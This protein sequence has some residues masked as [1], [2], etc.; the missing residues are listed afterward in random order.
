MNNWWKATIILLVVL[1]IAAFS[2]ALY[3]DNQGFKE[4]KRFCESKDMTRLPNRDAHVQCVTEDGDI[5]HY[6][7]SKVRSTYDV[8]GRN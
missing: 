4:E 8:F 6:S 5:K 1:W 3:V 2:I 7:R